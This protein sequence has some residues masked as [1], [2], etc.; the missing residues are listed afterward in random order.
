MVNPTNPDETLDRLGQGLIWGIPDE[1]KPRLRSSLMSVESRPV[2]HSALESPSKNRNEWGVMGALF[3]LSII[4]RAVA[5]LVIG[6]SYPMNDDEPEYYEPA[7]HIAEGKGYCR[8]NPHSANHALEPT[9]TAYRVPGPSIILAVGFAIVRNKSLAVAR[10]FSAF[11]ASFAAPLM[12]L[13]VRR[14]GSR[15]A[16]LLAGLACAVYPTYLYF[17]LRIFSQPYFV[18]MLL[19]GLLTTVWA[20]ESPLKW[21][22]LSREWFGA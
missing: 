6:V 7:V 13:L 18:P 4:A 9:P 22:C 19:L 20:I 10:L 12:Y 8:S 2:K 21:P 14:T 3:L 5:A 16:A 11:I 1:N 15:P 17:S